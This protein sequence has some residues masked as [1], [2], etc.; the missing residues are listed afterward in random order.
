M[1]AITIHIMVSVPLSDCAVA[2]CAV[3]EIRALA[4]RLNNRAQS[5]LSTDTP[6]ASRDMCL[7]AEVSS[8][9]GCRA[10]AR[11]DSGR[12]GQRHRTGRAALMVARIRPDN[13]DLLLTMRSGG[14][15]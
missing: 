11:I 13:G 14:E 5:P 9:A 15:R 8:G 7:G 6:E 10:G 4:N 12:P 2:A 3:D 1:Y